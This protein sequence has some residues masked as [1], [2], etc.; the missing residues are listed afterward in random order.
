MNRYLLFLIVFAILLNG[1]SGW[2]EERCASADWERIGEDDGDV[3]RP[4]ERFDQYRDYCERYGVTPDREAYD[5]GYLGGRDD[6]CT[7]RGGLEAGQ[8]G[9][10]YRGICKEGFDEDFRRGHQLGLRYFALEREIAALQSRREQL[11]MELRFNSGLTPERRG[12]YQQQSIRLRGQ[13]DRLADQ[14]QDLD[15]A[16][17]RLLAE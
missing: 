9:D 15:A 12:Y 13:I 14:R 5:L 16:A 8:R 10:R 4:P 2:S 7:V 6:Y 11:E 3:G 17:R 1:C